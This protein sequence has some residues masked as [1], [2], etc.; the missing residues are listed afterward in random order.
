MS[1]GR[2]KLSDETKIIHHTFRKDRVNKEAPIPNSDSLRAPNWLSKEDRKYFRIL[3]LEL[4]DIGLGSK[5]YSEMLAL[6]ASRV[7]EIKKCN[8]TLEEQGEFYETTNTRGSLIYKAHPALAQ[9]N[10]AKRHYQSLLAQFG[11]S[12]V[13]IGK[14]KTDRMKS[15]DNQQPFRQFN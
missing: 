4:N 2:P 10:E 6:A 11:L 12:P 13:D 15:K 5:S 7:I 3:K 14:T 1:K 8:K 9:R